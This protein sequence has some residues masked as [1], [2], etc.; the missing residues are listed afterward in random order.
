MRKISA[1]FIF[2]VTSRPLKNGIVKIDDDGKIYELTDTKG[3]LKEIPGLEF[4]N[5]I[6]VPGF[7]NTHCHLELS[8][9]KNLIPQNTGHS[10]FIKLIVD[11][12][13]TVKTDI[14]AIK[15][16][17]LEMQKQG[18]VAVGDISNNT[19]SAKIKN[20]SVIDYHTFIELADFFD[21]QIS[22]Q[23][24]FIAQKLQTKFKKSSIVAHSPYSCS[25]NF[26]KKTALLSKNIYS[27]HNQ[28][29]KTENQMY[30]S[31]KG[32]I[33]DMMKK[34]KL[35]NNFKPTGK[36]SLK[37]FLVKIIRKN[38]NIILVH[39]L[40]SSE[41]DIKFAENLSK[42]IYWAL[43]PNSNKYIQNKL[44]DVKIF[45]KNK[46]KITLGTDSLAS[47]TNL[48]ILE[49]MKTL[50]HISFNEILKWGTLN[51]AKS[52]KMDNKFG[53]IEKGKKPGLNLITNFNFKK[54]HLNANSKVK[55]II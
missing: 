13:A 52:L 9:L 34:R 22:E 28:E 55:K 25:L 40:F 30:L 48:S 47:N 6:I 46:C 31:G 39:N 49:E 45:L 41:D 4:Y 54:M 16:A 29:E 26:I 32:N 36:N 38:L 8:Y 12:I 35:F 33:A 14:E 51:G 10:D 17:D 2:P 21:K 20:K 7:I 27:I 11:K 18:I 5:G 53:S 15:K 43:C 23:K 24:I 3:K 37:S 19:D 50:K 1:N 44:P 42:N